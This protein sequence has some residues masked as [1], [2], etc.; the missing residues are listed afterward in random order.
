M[1][2]GNL[3]IY[4]PSLLNNHKCREI[5]ISKPSMSPSVPKENDS[6]PKSDD[7]NSK[8]TSRP[9]EFSTSQ[10]QNPKTILT[11]TKNFNK[12]SSFAP[13]IPN[14]SKIFKP[15]SETSSKRT[16]KKK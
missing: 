7:N 5:Q 2:D 13:Q 15:K 16:L 1:T 8:P 9:R 3:S 11:T 4:E 12:E 6:E 14:N 10:I